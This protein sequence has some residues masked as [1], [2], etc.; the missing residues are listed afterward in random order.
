MVDE[1]RTQGSDA[2]PCAGRQLEVLG[3]AAVEQKSFAWI[4]RVDEFQGV[5][6]LV[7]PFRIEGLAR[8]MLLPPV[9]RRN[10]RAAQT[11]FELA[12]IG[13]QLEFDAG[14]GQAD[15]AGPIEV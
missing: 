4:I 9:A 13:N 1:A 2:D 5:A 11:C 12:F 8:E 14:G 7:E 15:I 3:D 6:D 10:V